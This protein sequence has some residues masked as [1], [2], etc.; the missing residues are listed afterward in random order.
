M[1]VGA[2]LKGSLLCRCPFGSTYD[3][4]SAGTSRHYNNTAVNQ[5]SLGQVHK[6]GWNSLLQ[7]WATHT[8]KVIVWSLGVFLLCRHKVPKS[9]LRSRKVQMR[10]EYS[11]TSGEPK[12]CDNAVW[13]RF[14]RVVVRTADQVIRTASI[15]YIA[16]IQFFFALPLQRRRRETHSSIFLSF[17]GVD[18]TELTNFKSCPLDVV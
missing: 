18:F 16:K 6:K 4:T 1:A 2:L 17:S 10:P 5:W 13:R 12:F 9:F 7:N 11:R 14:E 8:L 15:Q 3:R